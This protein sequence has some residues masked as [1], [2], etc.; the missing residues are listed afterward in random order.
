[1]IATDNELTGFINEHYPFAVFAVITLIT[2][3]EKQQT[4]SFND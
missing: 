3:S 1:V 2:P 4:E